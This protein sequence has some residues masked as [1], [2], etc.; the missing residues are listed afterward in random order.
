MEEVIKENARCS[1]VILNYNGKGIVTKCISSLIES[2]YQDLEI[3][4][5]DNYSTDESYEECVRLL[6]TV[7]NSIA[8]KNNSNIGFTKGFNQG[9]SVSSGEYIILLNNDVI[10]EPDSISNYI[11]F[12]KAN[13]NVGLAEGRIINV[14]ND[15]SGLTSDPTIINFFG[16]LHEGGDKQADESTF[17]N[18]TRIYSPIG[19]WPIIRRST[20]LTLGG[21]DEDYYMFE[22]IR[23]LS[24]RVWMSGQEVG[25]VFDAVC[26]HVGRTSTFSYG[27]KT[28]EK[29]MF[30]ATKNSIMF[31][32]KNYQ[33][34]S[35]MKNF[36]PYLILRIIDLIDTITKLG[37][38]G[39]KIKL[40]AYIWILRNISAINLKRRFLNKNIRRVN[41]KIALTALRKASFKKIA[42][43]VRSR[44]EYQS[45]MNA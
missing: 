43:I 13:P 31:F 45:K 28:A 4:L 1:V 20:Y 33:V 37:I 7:P 36:F 32:L 27:K 42:F 19:A 16:I 38:G 24:A 8:I 35:I 15:V 25:Y 39:G 2:S 26:R 44:N 21:Y 12:M 17:Q 23:D 18:I 6:D 3:I 29:L 5:I 9:L 30:H 22:E 10:L 40:K 14:Y 41:D 11:K 34:V